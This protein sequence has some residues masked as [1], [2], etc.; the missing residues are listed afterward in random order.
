MTSRRITPGVLALLA[1]LALPLALSS[2]PAALAAGDS[3]DEAPAASQPDGLIA[4]KAAIEAK[5]YDKAIE[6]LEQAAE[7]NPDDADVHN[8]LGYAYRKLGHYEQAMTAY[9]RALELNPKHKG[10]LEYKGELYLQMG[11]RQ[12]AEEMAYTLR[13]ECPDGCEELTDLQQAI[14]QYKPSS[15]H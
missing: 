4:G 10:A 15:Q 2:V 6:Q 1:A 13:M 8:Y 14:K 5:D 3:S 11:M 9:D 7:R 12:K